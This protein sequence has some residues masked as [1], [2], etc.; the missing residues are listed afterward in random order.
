MTEE[1]NVSEWKPVET[2]PN[3]VTVDVW[4]VATRGNQ[5]VEYE[6]SGAKLIDGVWVYRDDDG[7]IAPIPEY[8]QNWSFAV[9]YWDH[10]PPPRPPRRFPSE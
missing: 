4:C 10:L 6:I 8:H 5:V 7:D 1:R 3:D 2:A 9:K